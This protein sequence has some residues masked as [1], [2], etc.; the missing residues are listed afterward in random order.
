MPAQFKS[1]N[2]PVFIAFVSRALPGKP[3]ARTRAQQGPNYSV[4]RALV[5]ALTGS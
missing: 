3:F 2:C 4:H 5:T 1:L